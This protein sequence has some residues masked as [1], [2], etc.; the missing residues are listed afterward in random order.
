MVLSKAAVW[1]TSSKPQVTTS[2]LTQPSCSHRH[3]R[4]VS[5]PLSLCLVL[6]FFLFCKALTFFLS[7]VMS[8]L[9]QSLPATWFN[10]TVKSYKIILTLLILFN[11]FPSSS[12]FKERKKWHP[13]SPG[14][15]P[16]IKYLAL[17]MWHFSVLLE[18]LSVTADSTIQPSDCGLQRQAN[19]N[20]LSRPKWFKTTKIKPWVLS[21]V[22]SQ[23]QKCYIIW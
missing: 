12:L 20:A 18:L 3:Q 13:S 7:Y 16:C 22:I 5:L 23:N 9:W 1:E 14:W 8:P 10:M 19:I 15:Q 17:D 2:L 4:A 11:N 21:S 6:C